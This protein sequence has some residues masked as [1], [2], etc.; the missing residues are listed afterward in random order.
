MTLLP[1]DLCLGCLHQHLVLFKLSKS[2]NCCVRKDPVYEDKA[3][4]CA[5]RT[6][7]N[8]SGLFRAI[9]I[10]RSYCW[11]CEQEGRGVKSNACF[12]FV[13]RKHVVYND[14]F[15]HLVLDITLIVA[16]RGK[17]MY[18]SSRSRNFRQMRGGGQETWYTSCW[19]FYEYFY[20]RGDTAPP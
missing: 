16:G 4:L 11:L 3:Q 1:C 7:F 13:E 6:L 9:I 17:S 2:A 5:K 14:Y 8:N 20:R 10:K 12:W 18:I 15:L 19:F